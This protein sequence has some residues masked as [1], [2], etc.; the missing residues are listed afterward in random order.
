MGYKIKNFRQI[1]K[2]NYGLIKKMPPPPQK[3]AKFITVLKGTN[4]AKD[5]F[6]Y[7][8]LTWRGGGEHFNH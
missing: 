4:L 2:Y 8:F 6:I 1:W 5:Q 3:K 7:I